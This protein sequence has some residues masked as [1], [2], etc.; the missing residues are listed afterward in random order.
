MSYSNPPNN[1]LSECRENGSLN[2]YW[3]PPAELREFFDSDTS[4]EV[5]LYRLKNPSLIWLNERV[6]HH[7]PAFLECDSDV[8]RYAKRLCE[9]CAYVAYEEE[10]K[11]KIIEKDRI[12]ASSDRYGGGAI[13]TNGG[14]G[15]AAFV[16]GYLVKGTGKTPL[17]GMHTEST[18]ATGGAYLE[19][20]IRETIFS[21]LFAYEFPHSSIPNIAVID[22]G[23]VQKWDL[24]GSIKTERR[25]LLVRPS[26]IRPA[27][28]ERAVYYLSSNF[29]E[30]TLDNIR[31][32]RVIKK[33]I[34]KTGNNGLS[35]LLEN[36]FINW[37]R[38]L[39]YGY[40][41]RISLG[42]NTTSNI[43]LDGK[44][45]DFGA[46]SAL[47]SWGSFTMISNLAPTGTEFQTV[48]HAISSV[49]YYFNKHSI[50]KINISE[51]IEEITSKSWSAYVNEYL[52]QTLR[53][54]GFSYESAASLLTGSCS[55]Y[56]R[57]VIERVHKWY[58]KYRFD[59]VDFTPLVTL[60]NGIVEV[61]DDPVPAHLIELRALLNEH[62]DEFELR[63]HLLNSRARNSA[64]P[65][66]FREEMKDRLYKEVE[67][68][69]DGVEINAYFMKEF[70]RG[71]VVRSRRDHRLIV[72][73]EF[74][75]DAY[76][77][78][79][80]F[81][82]IVLRSILN[83]EL[84]GYVEWVTLQS[85]LQSIITKENLVAE[86]RLCLKVRTLSN[87]ALE[88]QNSPGKKILCTVSRV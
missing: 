81:S 65:S 56:V 6:L 11:D 33:L 85:P 15:R 60:G 41:H 44:L 35:N 4:V 10:I 70:V 32:D 87:E 59:I 36:F 76:C 74:V 52:I 43:C 37:A 7:D 75:V 63:T 24:G 20:S 49:L 31:V 53:L 83:Q 38:Q 73:R 84:V 48:A 45:L 19:E 80:D 88:F 2:P 69:N 21:E 61:W 58:R 86:S 50:E 22:T 34:S 51:C 82:V 54:C 62:L 9:N 16:N 67:K 47:P 68:A 13:G 3:L 79:N 77:L 25:V 30:G 14:S 5:V 64:R 72:P 8:E 66:L 46:A 55:G 28:M 1:D 40:I 42:G 18:H 39:A 29:L 27:H 26:F 57:L 17:I 71:E 23:I 12:I 78:S